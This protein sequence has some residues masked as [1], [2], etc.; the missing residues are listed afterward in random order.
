MAVRFVCDGQ[1]VALDGV[2]PG[3]TVLDFLRARA[4]KT[5]TKEGCGEGD[6]GACTVL[7]GTPD[8]ALTWLDWRA[9][10]ACIQFLPMLHGKAVDG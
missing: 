1:L 4:G 8:A 5:G 9:V 7:V 6:C 3:D 10:N 2:A